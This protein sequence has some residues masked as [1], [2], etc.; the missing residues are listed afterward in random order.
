MLR[1]LFYLQDLAMMHLSL[2]QDNFDE[3]GAFDIEEFELLFEAYVH[4]PAQREETS[5]FR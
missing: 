3:L 4:F 1:S 5:Q 2:G